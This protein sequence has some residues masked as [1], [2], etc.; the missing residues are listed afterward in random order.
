MEVNLL[1]VNY[2]FTLFNPRRLFV[3]LMA[4]GLNQK[5]Y[6]SGFYPP[7][8][9]TMTFNTPKASLLFN[10]IHKN[11]WSLFLMRALVWGNVGIFITPWFP[12]FDAKNMVVSK[13]S[14]WVRLPY[15]PLLFW[16]HKVLEDIGNNLGRLRKRDLKRTKKGIFN[17]AS[18][19]V[20]TNLSKG[21]PNHIILK[22]INLQWSQVLEYENT[23]FRCTTFFQTCHL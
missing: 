8:H 16:H 5:H 17:F 20:E 19:C 21:L 15:L 18:I 11:I 9:P 7:R 1:E 13:I 6:A 3:G 4:F 14:V 12:Y 23:A 2:L 10:L 22:H